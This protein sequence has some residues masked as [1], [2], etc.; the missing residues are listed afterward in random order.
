MCY[1]KIIA[2]FN[3]NSRKLSHLGHHIH[4]WQGVVNRFASKTL[5]FLCLFSR[6]TIGILSKGERKHYP[7]AGIFLQSFS[8]LPLVDL[9]IQDRRL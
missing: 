3:S 2:G 6:L 4:S 9:Q 7:Q 8:F 1:L 5:S